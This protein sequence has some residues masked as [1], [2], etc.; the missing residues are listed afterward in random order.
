M[1]DA[2]DLKPFEPLAR[3]AAQGDRDAFRGLVDE[4]HRTVYRVALRVT[5]DR[6]DAEEVV[7]ETYIRVWEGIRSLR[8]PAAALAWICQISRY[9]ARDRVRH[10]VRRR[11]EPL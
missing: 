3:R 4:T 7:Q 11:T 10:Q 2:L 6:A 5:N 1:K 9:V 8:D